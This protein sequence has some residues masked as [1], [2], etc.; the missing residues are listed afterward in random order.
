MRSFALTSVVGLCAASFVA[1][2][3]C[4]KS[5][6]EQTTY[7]RSDFCAVPRAVPILEAMMALV[8]ADALLEKLA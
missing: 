7:E 6:P 2:L 3:S 8:I 4:S 1:L 5:E